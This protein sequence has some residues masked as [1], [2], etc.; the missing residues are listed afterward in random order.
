MG[1]VRVVNIYP[2]ILVADKNDYLSCYK[3]ITNYPAITATM[4]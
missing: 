3:P 4:H 1:H 2:S